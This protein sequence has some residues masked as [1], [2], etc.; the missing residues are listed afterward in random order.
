MRNSEYKIKDNENSRN[1]IERIKSREDMTD[2]EF[3]DFMK[4]SI[5]QAEN[6]KSVS[7]D[8]TFNELLSKFK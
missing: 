2:K 5:E 8:R 4:L 7:I 6:G 3:N 1:L